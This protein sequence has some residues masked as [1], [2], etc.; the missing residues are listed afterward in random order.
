[1]FISSEPRILTAGDAI[2]EALIANG[3]D[4][5]YGLPGAQLYPLFDALARRADRIRTYSARHEQTCGYMA[6]G[7]ARSTGRPGVFAVVPGPGVL[8]AGAALVTALATSTPV[9]CL[10]GQ[11]PSAFLGRGRGHLHEIPDQLATLRGLTKWAARI[12]RVEDAP[13]ILDEAFVRMLSGRPGPVAVEIAWDTLGQSAPIRALGPATLPAPLAP[14]ADAVEAAARLLVAAERPMIFLG[15]GARH[16]G[17]AVRELAELLDAPV[18]AFRGGRG[19]V[20]ESHPLGISAVAAHALWPET[21]ALIGIGTRLELPYMRWTGM[22]RLIDRPVA[23][24]HLVRID[25]DP[26][27][28]TRLVAHAPIL[29]DA[30]TGTRALVAAVRRLAADRPARDGGARRAVI[31]AAKTQARARIEGVQ[32]QLGFL[33]AIRRA[34]PDDGFLVPELCQVGFTSYIGFDVRRPR[35]YVSEGYQGTLGA[36]FPTALGVKAA[37][38][39]APV[40]SVTGDGGFLF[41]VGDLATAV[42]EGLA[43]VVVVFDNGAYGNV[44][45]DQKTAFD[46]RVLGSTLTNP[47]FPALA[48]AF[49]VDARTAITAADLERELV[50]ALAARRPTVIHVPIEPDSEVSAWPFIHPR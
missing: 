41:G 33:D 5:V 19:I 27:E 40:I 44:R 43:L 15:T 21:D 37:H 8:N 18:T 30:E 48:R 32:P 35:T 3:I 25:V 6:F 17:D 38:P 11:V 10:T 1:M 34:L 42:Q 2:V 24:P 7:H 46:G 22:M 45:R 26:E 14:S 36:G 9:L 39:D 50:S 47:D 20:P 29:A 4:A 31:A 13:A 49:G 16:A 28:M 23:P 12:E